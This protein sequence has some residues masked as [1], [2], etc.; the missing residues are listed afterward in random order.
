MRATGL[1]R[2]RLVPAGRGREREQAYRP[3][4]TV[5]VT[6]GTGALGAHVARWLAENGAERI[7]LASR[8]GPEAAG[9][10]EL[11]AELEA[12]GA[13]A[14]AARCDLADRA[15]LEGLLAEIPAECPLSGVFHLAGA[16][17]DG[18]LE[19]LTRERLGG[20]LRAKVDAAWLLHELTDGMELDAFVLFSS[21]AGTLGGGGQGA[22]AAG[23]AFLD[24]LAEFRHGRGLPASAI[25]WGPWVGEGMAA[26]LGERLPAAGVRAMPADLALESLRWVL[27]RGER[28]V[29]VA[30]VDRQ[31]VLAGGDSVR[32]D[33]EPAA[34]G[35]LAA[36]LREVPD[37][38]RERVVLQLVREQ[39]AAVLG[40][41]TVEAVEAGRAFKELGFDSLAGVQLRNR[42]AAATGLR[43]ASS[44]VF[45]HPTPAA[46]AR[47]L[48]GE[49]T[50]APVG[51]RAVSVVGPVDEPIAIVGMGCRYPGP[52]QSG[53]ARTAR[54]PQQLWE[55]IA[56][57]GEG[58]GRFPTDRGWD[59]ER[60]YDPNRER[61]GTSSAREGG[62]LYD[63]GEFDAAFFGIGPREALAMD[64]QQRL[65]LEVCWETLEDAGIDPESLRGSPSGVFAGISMH[66]YAA[67][68]VSGRM[69]RELEGYLGTGGAGSVVSGRVAYTFGLEGPA[70]TV[71][72][73]CS[74]SLVAL[75]WAAQSLR[76][77]ECTLALAGGVTVMA[78]PAVFVEFSRQQ[79]LAVDG[80]CK[81]FA[82][83]ADGT[84]WGEGAGVLLLERLSDAQRNGHRV[85]A[86]VRGS[87]VNQDG[88]SNGLT[89]PNGPSQQRVIMQALAAAGMSAGDVDAVEAHG[90]GTT[91]GDPIE[92][93]ALLA[94]YGQDRPRDAPL[95]LGSVKSNIGHTQAAAGV[96]G[97]IKMAMALRH[98]RL[99][100]T[101][102]VDAPTTEVDWSAG[103]VALL[104]QEQP[105][106]PN[107]CPRRA[108]VSSFGVSGTNAHVILEEAPRESAPAL[109]TAPAGSGDVNALAGRE[110]DAGQHASQ[111]AHD[112][113]PVAHG[114]FPAVVPLIVSGRGSDGLRAQAMQLHSFLEGAPELDATDVAL[115]LAAR[116]GLEHRAVMLIDSPPTGA[117]PLECLAR[118]ADGQ[119]A[120]NLL[121]GKADGGRTAFLFTGQGAQRVGMGRELYGAFPAFAAAFD[122]VCAHL[123]PHLGRS[124]RDLV[125][126]GETSVRDGIDTGS[127]N[128]RSANGGGAN[129]GAPSAGAL[130][131]TALAQPAL[132]ALEVALYRLLE[133]W[134]VRPDFLIGHSVGELAAAHVAGVFSLEDAC[135]VVAARGRLMGALPAGGAMAAIA[136]TEQEL[137][138]S[139]AGLEGSVAVAAVNAPGAVVV[140]GD[141]DAV[142]ALVS[143]WEGRGRRTKRL[144]VSHAFHSPRMEGMLEEFRR[145]VETVKFDEPRL[146]LVSNLDGGMA[147]AELCTAEYWVRQVRETVRFADGVRS[148]LDEGV[149]TFL[150]L[151]PEGALSAMVAECADVDASAAPLLRAG[152]GE[153]RSLYTALARAWVRG[154]EVNWGEALARAG[155]RRVE[156]P[157]YAF[158]RQ[159]YWIESGAAAGDAAAAG[160]E[161]VEHPLLSAA[162]ALAE[163]EGRLFT[164]RVSLS[165][166][167]WLADHVVLGSVLLPGTALLE[168]ALHA[169]GQVGCETVAEL[170]LEAPLAIGESEAVQL[171]LTVGEPQ[172]SGARPIAI[173][174]RTEGGTWTRHARG[175]LAPGVGVVEPGDGVPGRPGDGVVD[176]P[177]G[178]LESVK[179]LAGPW[180]PRGASEIELDGMYEGLAGVGLDYG[181]AFQGL[182]RVWRHGEELF[183]EVALAPAQQHEAGDFEIHP[184]L[185]DAALHTLAA[186]AQG[187]RA[188]VPF[189]W[190]GVTMRATG[191]TALRVHVIHTGADTIAL[192]VADEEGLPV[193]AID[194]LSLR[195][196]SAAGTP[197]DSLFKIEWL[198][199]EPG[200]GESVD[201]DR[202]G[203]VLDCTATGT[204]GVRGALK[205]V[206]DV[207]AALQGELADDEQAGSCFAVVTRGAVSVAGEGVTDPAGGGV[208]GLVR[209]AQAEHP[210]RFVLVDVDS[211]ELASGVAD[212]DGLAR[213]ASDSGELA[214]GGA[215]GDGLASGGA[216]GDGLA[217]GG[218]DGDGLASGGADG[219]GLAAGGADGDGLASG[220]ADGDGLAAGGADGDGLASGA[221]GGG[222]LAAG[223]VDGGGAWR[224]AI[225]EALRQGEPEVAVRGGELFVPRLARAT[226]GGL[227][228]GRGVGVEGDGEAGGWR[229]GVSG[230][231]GVLED[232]RVVSGEG[233]GGGPLGEGEV[234]VG[235]RV[236]GVNFRDVLIALGMYPG[237]AAVGSEGAGVVLE[238]GSEVSDLA[239]G[240]RVMGLL[241]GAFGSVAI[242][243]QRLLVRTPEEWSF[244][245]AASAPIVFLT[246]YYGLVDL[247]KARKGER[248]LV[249]AAA[250]GVGIAAVQLAQQ[251]G[252]EVYATASEGKWGVLEAMGLDGEHIASS[253]SLEFGERFAGAG[254]GIVLNALA[255]EYVDA[256]LGLLG[257]GGRFLEM[258]KT[259]VRDAEEIGVAFPGVSYRAFDLME[260][261]PDRIQEMLGEL[262]ALFEEGAL[263]GLPVRVW[264]AG[265]AVDAFRFMSQARHVGKNVLRIPAP[266]LGGW[267]TVLITGGTG[268][269]GALVARHLVTGHG[270]R[271]LLLASRGG[272]DAEGAAELARELEELGASVTV[273]ACD[274]AERRQ[275][276]RLLKRIDVEHPLCAVVHAAGVLDDGLLDGLTKERLRGV[277][278]PKVGGRGICTR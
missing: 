83:A 278:A 143:V 8:G 73:A 57:G 141:E 217:A 127:A 54:T 271:Y 184:A 92:A 276:K 234:R 181:P 229:L 47:H 174:A 258:G 245:R 151:G 168:L 203:G 221:V 72:T 250:G 200:A 17:D 32:L 243:D 211:S 139:I 170:V 249:H 111:A 128:G 7:V 44:L 90:T 172:E 149:R 21:I 195:V 260:A 116:A 191:S 35:G 177:D 104:T 101:L 163:G 97:V 152:E 238:V 39:A 18:L 146:P 12:L 138:E 215:D 216:D 197:Q 50:G 48:L 263:E 210:G 51:V 193:A 228:V 29:I 159:R 196:A 119:S 251:L 38:E 100:R 273:A 227:A 252:L 11:V 214:A 89:A 87:A 112:A 205:R 268:G 94:T 93:Q 157:P 178:V 115:E 236:A 110:R 182:R 187:G 147:K 78:S 241:D 188:R 27:D 148:L 208:W 102:H 28:H 64:P 212:G 109:D 242:A 133:A 179:A 75:H 136:A 255:G 145:I 270:V 34:T 114:G 240:D 33:A 14:T 164:G 158:Q 9:A 36:R 185:L 5:L 186:T 55:L 108:G 2:R 189:S 15:Q 144:R 277:L 86:L 173:H 122:E 56:A 31:R 40:H 237:D 70:V 257:E 155:A 53:G 194:S 96:A 275:V 201:E 80:R 134:G 171:Q 246:A 126:A 42:L 124:L 232:L 131:E 130:D 274:V 46:L 202:L 82:D 16:L 244:A 175:L 106:Q 6:G 84:G 162:V 198:A 267:G 213:G 26:G 62:F 167:P 231:G 129:G 121:Q 76:A 3:R 25:A 161:R 22:Y 272:P 166:H 68:G 74:S 135:R 24:A 117:Q 235:V 247:A 204:V 123:D 98:G 225:G 45:D 20:V 49:T 264:E 269:L 65:L 61:A 63:A 233:A 103:A 105:W 4:G 156:L 59:L 223:A 253:R 169:G 137:L 265:E 99:P 190:S 13:S 91:L 71:D 95:W 180:P 153:P 261:G 30:D 66:D 10:G 192:K 219:D 259:D 77:G 256:S 23:N 60:L 88:A 254:I 85:H 52:V 107:G 248:V 120:E 142:A 209:A 69:A 206:G 79:G 218:A 165:S 239:V 132:F 220:G 154:A 262:V 125:F 41:A 150:E 226:A 1:F 230:G 140:S 207:L 160:Q 58:I 224:D 19:G 113:S 81:S 43:L 67:A 183:A 266:P 176:T 222:G 118:L 37:G 199:L